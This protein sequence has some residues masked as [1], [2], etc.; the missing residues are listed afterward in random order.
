MKT[1]NEDSDIRCC[2]GG[3]VQ[4]PKKLDERHN[5]LWFL[6]ERLKIEHEKL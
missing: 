5:D 2:I 1:Y 4:Y 3:N 6:P